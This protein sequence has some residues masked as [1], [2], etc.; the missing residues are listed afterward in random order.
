MKF[1]LIGH[2]CVD[3]LRGA[4]GTE[5]RL[6]GG[7]YHAVAA[8]SRLAGERDTVIPVFGAGRDDLAALTERFDAFGNVDTGGLF[9]LEQG[10][11]IVR[12]DEAHPGER[13][14]NIAP[15]I[16]FER[17]RKFL[18][19]DAVYVN[20]ISG[21]DISLETLDRIRLEVR[22]RKVPVHLDLHCLTLGVNPDGSR[23]RRAVSDWRRWCFMTDS[24]QMNQEEAQGITMEHWDDNSFAKQ[25]MP[26]MVKAFIIT[27]G[28]D[29]V[30]VYQD[31]HK[32]LRRTD[33][34]DGANP[35]PVSTVGSGDIF[36]AAFLYAAAKKRDHIT[37]ARYAHTVA[38][39]STRFPLGAKHA[40][41]TAVRDLP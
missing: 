35:D 13:V 38:S 5:E 6:F 40:E 37:A 8:L 31:E 20:M 4:D 15:P 33:I 12:Y 27:R 11:G 24:V 39:Y 25:M 19:A 16:P 41:L 3:V 23:F 17:I 9:E 10:S 1:T 32:T 28:G 14:E 34:T 2:L 26:L 36:G 18:S 21:R 30:T 29:G 7:I 22:S